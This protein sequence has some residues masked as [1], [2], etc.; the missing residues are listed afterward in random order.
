MDHTMIY[1]GFLLKSGSS[2]Y[3][4]GDC[5][6]WFWPAE[7]IAE[8]KIKGTGKMQINF[9]VVCF[10][11]VGGH[12]RGEHQK[13]WREMTVVPSVLHYPRS[14]IWADAYWG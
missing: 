9:F 10:R 11:T 1:G 4:V 2:G 5:V 3:L 7:G 14:S 8:W 12:R 13:K 6:V